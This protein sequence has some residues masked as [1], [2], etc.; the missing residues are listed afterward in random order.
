MLAATGITITP[1]FLRRPISAESAGATGSEGTSVTTLPV[2][3]DPVC[4]AIKAGFIFSVCGRSL[5][6]LV[7]SAPLLTHQCKT[8]ISAAVSWGFSFGGMVATAIASKVPTRVSSLAIA[9]SSSADGHGFRIHPSVVPK[10]L[11]ALKQGRFQ[12]VLLET[13]VPRVILRSW[14]P[15]IQASWED[16]LRLEGFPLATTLKQL[17]LSMTHTVKGK[18]DKGKYP[19]MFLHGSLDAFT[20]MQNSLRMQRLI[21]RAKLQII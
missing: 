16:I 14:G 10:L 5:I 17:R 20:P 2:F 21:A 15:E 18:L 3:D 1:A 9:G 13:V 11:L 8:V 12:D 6:F 4:S 19:V 7:K